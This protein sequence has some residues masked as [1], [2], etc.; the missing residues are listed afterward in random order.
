MVLVKATKATG[1]TLE[2]VCFMA[3]PLNNPKK[4]MKKKQ[5]WHYN[6]K[7]QLN[8]WQH[9]N[10][11]M[12]LNNICLNFENNGKV[13]TFCWILWTSLNHLFSVYNIYS[14]INILLQQDIKRRKITRLSMSRVLMPVF[15]Q[16]RDD[17]SWH[18][19]KTNLH[20]PACQA[21]IALKMK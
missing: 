11:Y 8:C 15:R 1:I 2:T 21:Q 14:F 7:H 5:S 16:N 9:K 3:P 19:I 17:Q 6:F 12:N 10:Y 20:L 4:Q 13:T 18:C